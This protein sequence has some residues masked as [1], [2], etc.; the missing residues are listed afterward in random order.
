MCQGGT[1]TK[2]GILGGSKLDSDEDWWQVRKNISEAPGGALSGSTPGADLTG[3]SQSAG[4]GVAS[5]IGATTS[6]AKGFK[7][8]WYNPMF[9]GFVEDPISGM[10]GEGSLSNMNEFESAQDVLSNLGLAEG[11]ASKLLN[12][13]GEDAMLLKGDEAE[14]RERGLKLE[15]DEAKFESELSSV[16]EG[17]EGAEQKKKESIIENRVARQ[18]AQSDSIP[19]YEKARA[20]VAKSGIAYSGPA[21]ASVAA[22]DEAREMSMGDISRQSA[23]IMKDYR[24]TTSLLEGKKTQAQENIDRE[25]QLFSA[26]LAGML[27]RTQ[28]KASSILSQ[29]ASLPQKWRTFGEQ[30]LGGLVG[31]DY[32]GGGMD[33]VGLFEES[34]ENIQGLTKLQDAVGLAESAG[35]SMKDALL[36]PDFFAQEG[37]GV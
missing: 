31:K 16:E 37:E 32:L 34:G 24:D 4:R 5:N 22:S 33:N 14:F 20:N 10:T 18:Q 6:E 2:W 15:A 19:E 17:L 29:A 25:R 1:K 13:A 35:L 7:E 27:D 30:K 3:F 8:N 21:M 11:Q 28:D 26:G 12:A 36:S 23:N 9:Q